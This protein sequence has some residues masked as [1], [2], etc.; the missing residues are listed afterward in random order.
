MIFLSRDGI[1]FAGF[2]FSGLPILQDFTDGTVA[3]VKQL[4][5]SFVFRRDFG[6]N[7]GV[8]WCLHVGL[9]PQPCGSAMFVGGMK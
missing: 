4:R 9:P 1:Y 8:L 5:A 7:Y 2:S 6:P 3:K